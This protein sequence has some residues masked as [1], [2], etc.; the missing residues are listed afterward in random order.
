MQNI[1][2]YFA[3]GIRSWVIYCLLAE[4]NKKLKTAKTIVIAEFA[5]RNAAIIPKC[6]NIEDGM[7]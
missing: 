4:F 5:P 7:Y 6:G 3:F 1:T 2:E